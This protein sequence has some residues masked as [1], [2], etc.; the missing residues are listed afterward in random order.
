MK[1]LHRYIFGSVGSAALFGAGLFAFVLVA[2]NAVKD[3]VER[4]ASGQLTLPVAAHMVALLVPFTL[5]FAAPMGL[6]VGILVVLGRMSARNEIVALKSAGLSLWRISCSIVVLS[7]IGAGICA[8][9]NNYY[10]PMARAQY[11]ELLSGIVHEAPLRFI[12]PGRF[13]RDFPGYVIYAGE[14]DG[15]RLGNVWIWVLGPDRQVRQF[16]QA[17]RG[18]ISYDA[19]KNTLILDVAQATGESRGSSSA[20]DMGEVRPQIVLDRASFALPM[21][22]LMSSQSVQTRPQKLSNMSLPQLVEVRDEAGLGMGSAAPGSVEF[23]QAEVARTRASFY[24]SRN[25][26]FAFSAVALAMLGIPL[27]IQVGRQ[28]T[29]ANMAIALALGLLYFMFVFMAGWAERTPEA[30]PQFMVWLP[31]VGFIALGVGLMI[32]ANRH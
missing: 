11:R 8:Y 1:L 26:A 10:A 3:V 30:Y 28:E 32:R 15:E 7:L 24:I 4:V 9:V 6:L 16:L 14:R 2:A 27:G 18:S 29:Y 25:F 31:N 19:A 23:R 13:V 20:D 12:V 5:S 17:R 22:R 21:D